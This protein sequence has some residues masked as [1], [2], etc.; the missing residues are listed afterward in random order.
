MMF[1]TAL[2]K[3]LYFTGLQ[4]SQELPALWNNTLMEYRLSYRILLVLGTCPVRAMVAGLP[5][6]LFLSFMLLIIY[7]IIYTCTTRGFSN[8]ARC[9]CRQGLFRS[10]KIVTAIIYSIVSLTTILI[11]ASLASTIVGCTQQFIS[12]LKSLVFTLKGLQLVITG[13]LL[14]HESLKL[15]KKSLTA[16]CLFVSTTIGGLKILPDL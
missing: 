13:L 15:V 16:S 6:R 8:W 3:R 4:L 10:I 2:D 1:L 5:F 11:A 12:I 7:R 14:I 9:T